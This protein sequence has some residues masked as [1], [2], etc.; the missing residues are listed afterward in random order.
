MHSGQAIRYGSAAWKSHTVTALLGHSDADVGLH[1]LT[2]ALLGTIG[3]GD[4]GAHYPPT[5]PQWRGAASEIFL[6]DAVRRLEE[7]NGRIVHLDVTLV[8]ERPNIAEHRDAMRQAIARIARVSPHRV[9]VKATTSE[10]LGFTGRGE[11]IAAFA[12]ATVSLPAERMS[13][14]FEMLV[15]EAEGLLIACRARKLR[16]STAE[17]CTGGLLAAVLTEV[18]GSSDVFERGFVTYSNEAKVEQLAVPWDVISHYG[19]VSDEAARAMATGALAHSRADIAVAITGI[20]GPGGGSAEKP[21]GLVHLSAAQ[22]GGKSLQKE[23]RV[24]D[25]GR[26][27]VRLAAV[28]EAM[29]LLGALL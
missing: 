15:A 2:D 28:R 16:I 7:R 5:D 25:I 13:P 29:V 26:G 23:M 18:P 19:A 10:G 8:C 17:S 27:A 20:A 1:A 21:V 11:G 14:D 4:I 6:R 9:S 22:R 12:V 3:D 24:G